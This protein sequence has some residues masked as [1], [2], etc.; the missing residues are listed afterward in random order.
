MVPALISARN[1]RL[2]ERGNDLPLTTLWLSFDVNG[3]YYGHNHYISEVD[4]HVAS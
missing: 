1:L 2:V 3:C 4:A